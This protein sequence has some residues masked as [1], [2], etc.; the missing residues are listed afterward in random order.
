M[1][2]AGG[3]Q[4]PDTGYKDLLSNSRTIAKSTQSNGRRTFLQELRRQTPGSGNKQLYSSPV[5]DTDP[6]MLPEFELEIEI[7]LGIEA[8]GTLS[9]SSSSGGEG[10]HARIPEEQEEKEADGGGT[11]SDKYPQEK[12][13]NDAS[14]A[15]VAMLKGS[16]TDIKDG[17][18]DST[19]K[20][21]PAQAH[22]ADAIEL[23]SKAGN[24]LRA[25]SVPDVKGRSSRQDHHK[26]SPA[27]G[28]FAF[29][30]G[31][32]EEE[33][34]G[35]GRDTAAVVSAKPS[36]WPSSPL[37]LQTVRPGKAADYKA[38]LAANHQVNTTYLQKALALLLAGAAKWK[39]LG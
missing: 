35:S 36:G 39:R 19:A 22:S 5:P 16:H 9:P 4:A 2:L 23:Q 17:M 3:R 14:K 11:S 18:E 13:L 34:P 31:S 33:L 21:S 7:D 25:Q 29:A 6:E 27:P 30:K 24:K 12:L 1:S 20:L 26:N 37:V 38:A 10:R 28:G 8:I 15:A 32:W